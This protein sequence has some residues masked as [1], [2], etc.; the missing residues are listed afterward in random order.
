MAWGAIVMG[1]AFS[2]S[3]CGFGD[4]EDFAEESAEEVGTDSAASKDGQFCGG[5]GG[6]AC[7]A[8]Y[9]CVDDPS[10]TCDPRNGGADCGGICVKAARATETVD[11]TDDGAKD[12]GGP[13]KHYVLRDSTQC[14]AVTFECAEG[15]SPFFDDCGCGCVDSEPAPSA[16]K[17]SAKGE[18]CGSKTC[19]RGEYCCNLSCS[20]CVPDGGF[21][22]QQVCEGPL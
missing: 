19:G 17:S 13:D 18:P 9:T 8:G 15:T 12:C 10:D 21:C 22:T 2:V 14:M 7:P 1:A 3:A 16:S 11:T 5:F 4:E 6:I 20:I